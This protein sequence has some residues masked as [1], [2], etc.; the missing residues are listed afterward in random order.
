MAPV[1]VPALFCEDMSPRLKKTRIIYLMRSHGLLNYMWRH[2][3]QLTLMPV[4]WL[5]T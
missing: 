3:D 4:L 2:A 5:L 1:M